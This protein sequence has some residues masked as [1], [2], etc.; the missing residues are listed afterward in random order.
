MTN[1]MVVRPN[2]G[3]EQVDLIKRTICKGASDDEMQMFIAQCNRTG[4]D[5]FSRQIYSVRRRER[6]ANGYEEKMVTQVSIDGLRLI[7]ERSG[8]YAGQVGPFWCGDDGQWREVWLEAEPPR[9]AKCGIMRSDFA[10]PL[11]AVARYDTYR[12]DATDRSGQRGPTFFW[13]KMPDLMIGKCAEALALRRAFPQ[14]L[15]GLYIAEEMVDREQVVTLE[16]HPQMPVM[17]ETLPQAA[18]VEPKGTPLTR[19]QQGR[20]DLID[21]LFKATQ[22]FLEHGIDQDTMEKYVEAPRA[23][24]G[25]SHLAKLRQAMTDAKSTAGRDERKLSWELAK[26]FSPDSVGDAVDAEVVEG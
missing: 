10:E 5:P 18:K 8:K 22:W 1:E 12:Q 20:V 16:S 4:L 6:T 11:F 13:G 17:P 7:A 26:I 9:A 3:R 23:E 2:M 24:W 19:E 14:E 21:R 25:E 15:S